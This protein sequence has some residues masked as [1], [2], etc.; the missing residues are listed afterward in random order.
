MGIINDILD[1]S[2]IE[3]DKL[4]M[5][6]I[7]FNLDDVMDNLSDLN[8]FKAQEKGLELVFSKS[9]NVPIRLVGDPLRL[10]QVLT[11]LTNNAI[12]F[13]KRGEVIVSIESVGQEN[14]QVKLQ[15]AVKDTGVGL[16]KGQ[17]S[18]L[19]EAFSQADGSTTRKYGGTGLGLAISK[20]M[21]ELMGGEIWV[22]SESD[23][24]STFFFTAAF[25][26]QSKDKRK[27]RLSSKNLKG[28]RILVVD[29]NESTRQALREYLEAFSF[30]V[31]TDFS[32]EAATKELE[33]VTTKPARSYD[34]IIMDWQIPVQIQ[35]FKSK[36]SEI[37]VIV[38][39]PAYKWKDAIKQIQEEGFDD[40]IVKPV[41]QSF[42]FDAVM[43]I[44][45][46]EVKKRFKSA[47]YGFSAK[48]IFENIRGARILLVEDNEINQEVVSELLE[49]EGFWVT[50][51]NNGQEAVEKVK[52]DEFDVI[53]MDL[54][55]PVMDGYA[56][57]RS[58]RE[59]E[60]RATS[61][62][63]PATS[64]PIIAMTA[65][66]V[67]GV[68]QRCMEAGM[69]E[70]ITKP[71]EPEE[72]FGVLAVWIK[73]GDRE[74]FRPEGIEKETFP[75]LEG[76][77]VERGLG[78]VGGDRDA[79][80]R[81]LIQFHK[82]NAAFVDR[83]KETMEEGNHKR[84]M[85]M[86]HIFN[87]ASERIGA[88][89][90]TAARDELEKMIV[91]QKSDTREIPINQLQ[92]SLDRVLSSIASL[93]QTVEAHKVLAAEARKTIK[94]TD[95]SAITSLLSELEG[96]LADNDTEASVCLETL[97]EQ[98]SASEIPHPFDGLEQLI[99]QYDFKGALLELDRIKEKLGIA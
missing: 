44:F 93:E 24:G 58:I 8:G 79:Y 78:K 74:V 21:V 33:D 37:P 62:E 25:D 65:D 34:L 75:V 12:K 26:L 43:K 31:T 73:P 72:L 5:E 49:N 51:V 40:Y 29:D 46:Q 56:A 57:S 89:D 38:M 39:I 59:L 15:F 71:I 4:E 28:M 41:V 2:K 30:N 55:M 86:L 17:I 70:Y 99:E 68:R 52:S 80:R 48:E 97:K 27:Y 60:Q 42:L 76:I 36:I 87:E 19:F 90:L 54:Q 53:L 64:I 81:L 85:L 16:S 45:G 23:K 3:A 13:T 61:N 6:S 69:D 35:N 98:F 95:I 82:N 94:D 66:A 9:P 1:F 14:G 20:Q 7:P 96:F 84:A 67:V 11:N 47:R 92:L 88:N 22:E 83:L 18:K 77:D 32:G 10:G 50:V 63:Q 91:Q